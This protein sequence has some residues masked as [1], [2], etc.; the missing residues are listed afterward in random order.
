MVGVSLLRRGKAKDEIL[1]KLL[2]TGVKSVSAH[3]GEDQA[4]TH[5]HF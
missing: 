1:G 3:S 5:V 2:L 4:S